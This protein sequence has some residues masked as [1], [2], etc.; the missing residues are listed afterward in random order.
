MDQTDFPQL[1][2]VTGL[3]GAGISAALKH[4]EDIGYEAFDNFPLSMIAPLLAETTGDMFTKN[5]PIAL[6][7][8]SRTRGFNPEALQTVARQTGAK[9]LFLECSDAVLQQRFSETRRL[10]PMAKDRPV[11][12]GI[13]HERHWLSP[14]KQSADLTIN[15]S[16]M[17]I[18]DLK[19]LLHSEFALDPDTHATTVTLMSFGFK[20]GVPRQLDT[21]FDVRFLK[22]PHWQDDLRP[23]TGKDQAVQDYIKG[24]EDFEKF[25]AA[26][27]DY[28]ALTLPRYAREGKRYFTIG[29]GCTGGKHR[30]VFMAEYFAQAVNDLGFQTAIRHHELDK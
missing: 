15:T 9:L 21:L 13:I 2:L 24:D 18:H 12:D 11:I 1:L 10:H 16:D 29:F 14:L 22:N 3:S 20:Y 30:S 6:G 27:R 8:D 23:L 17:T 7:I 4:L 25:I 5:R 28:L 26:T 19:S